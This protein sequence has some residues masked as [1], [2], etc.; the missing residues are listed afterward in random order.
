[1]SR[2][3]LFEKA[4]AEARGLAEEK[5]EPMAVVEFWNPSRQFL[6]RTLVKAQHLVEKH[7]DATIRC[8]VYPKAGTLDGA[9]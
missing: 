8:R 1:M 9:Q 4:F 7:P 2:Y 5:S 3:R 6:V